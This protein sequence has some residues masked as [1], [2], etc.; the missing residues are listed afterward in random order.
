VE[1]IGSPDG[2]DGPDGEFLRR[3]GPPENELPVA[4]PVTALLARTPDAAVAV[5]GLQVY[6]TG[7]SMTLLVR[8]RRPLS[9]RRG[10]HELV[11]GSD[12]GGLRVGVGLADG[13]RVASGGVP[14]NDP[15]LVWQPTGGRGRDRSVEQGWWLSPLPPDGPLT[16]VVRCPGLGIGETATELDGAAIRAAAADVVELWPWTPPSRSP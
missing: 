10:L 8:A 13:R 4:L 2:E 1:H 3:T 9:P 16:V 15:D 14:R 7:V 5:V 11:H 6:S 12:G